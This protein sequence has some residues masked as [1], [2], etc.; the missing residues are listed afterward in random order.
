MHLMYAYTQ[1]NIFMA[2]AVVVV[3][4]AGAR[5][6]TRQVGREGATMPRSCLAVACSN[7]P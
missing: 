6:I 2:A 4:A 1:S 7:L 3:V 5:C